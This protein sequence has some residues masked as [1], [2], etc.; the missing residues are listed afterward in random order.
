MKR[1]FLFFIVFIFLFVISLSHRA[2]TILSAVTFYDFVLNADK[3]T[4]QNSSGTLP[5]PGSTSD[6][7]GFAVLLTNQ[8]MEDGS[9]YSKVLE[10][11]PEWKDKT[12]YISGTYPEIT[13]PQGAKLELRF[14]FLNGATAT[15]GVKYR[16]YFNRG[17]PVMI[18]E[19]SKNYTRSLESATVDLSNYYEQKGSFMLY[20]SVYATSTQDWACWVDAKIVTQGFPDLTITNLWVDANRYVHYRIKNIGEAPVSP[21]SAAVTNTLYLNGVVKSSDAFTRTIN[22]GEEYESYF[23]NYQYPF[24]KNNET[25]RVCADTGNVIKESNEG[26]NCNE[27]VET[28]SL[29]GIK[30]DTGCT[31]V[32]VEIYN[33]KGVLLQSGLSDA[34]SFYSTGLILLSGSYKVVLSKEGCSFEPSERSVSVSP[35][36]VFLTSFVC[37]CRKGPDLLISAIDYSS[38]EGIISYKVKNIGDEKTNSYFT[39]SLYIDGYYIAEDYFN[40]Y[41]NPGEE[42]SRTFS[43]S[44]VPGP[45]E[46]A[47]KVCADFKY[48]V[49]ES[50]ESNNCFEVKKLFPDLA[51]VSIECDYKEKSVRFA[52][53]NKGKEKVEKPFEVAIYVDGLLKSTQS[54]SK[55]IGPG[56]MYSS[57]FSGVATLC[58]DLNLKIVVDSN[59]KIPEI[60]EANNFMLKECK[61]E[62]L[63]DLMVSSVSLSGNQICYKVKNS[64]KKETSVSF[65][66]L[67]LIDGIKASEDEVSQKI[68]MEKEL[69]RCFSYSLQ[70]G[71]HVVKVCADSG[72]AVRESNEENNC[73]EQVFVIEERL[74]DIIVDAIQ[75][76]GDNEI[77]FTVKNIGS[78]FAVS[79]WSAFADVYFNG[80][81]KGTID[82]RNPS[83]VSGGGFEK[84]NG[85]S[86]YK[87]GW[88]ANNSTLVRILIDFTNNI[89][90]TDKSNN[91]KES[92]IEPCV[93]K[94]PDLVITE[95]TVIETSI[96]YTIKNIGEGVAGSRSSSLTSVQPTVTPCSALYVD[97]VMISE[98]C[99]E[100]PLEPGNEAQGHFVLH[101]K[102]TPPNEVIKVCADWENKINETD[103]F[104]NCLERIIPVEEK[105]PEK[106]CGC[107]ETSKFSAKVTGYDGFAV[108]N[109]TGGPEAEIVIAI[110]D[111]APG[112]AGMFYIYG[113]DGSLISKFKARFTTKDR[114]VVG[115]FLKDNIYQE[116]AV[117]IDED[118]KVYIYDSTGIMLSSFSA[119]FTPF[120][121]LSSGNLQ[122]DGKDEIIIAIDEDDKVYVYT[123]EGEKILEYQIPWDFDGANYLGE[124]SDHN[125]AV[126]VGN[127]FGD[128]YDEVLLLDQNG[129]KSLVYI[130]SIV[131]NSLLLKANLMVRFTKYDVLTTGNVIG[132]EREEIIIA[133]DED[134]MIYVYDAMAGL[135]KIRYAEITPVD[136]I[137]ASNLFGDS[138]DE[139]ILAQDDH[140]YIFIFSEEP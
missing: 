114:I 112:D 124:K 65:K 131:G 60:S 12:G 91:S 44:Y 23:K 96:S 84:T 100:S 67:L 71:R 56:E 121:T 53:E 102:P 36:Q 22:P 55:T 42:S 97:G 104:N 59:E 120:D 139:I 111:D 7:R 8:L 64:G 66:N 86:T 94:L 48:Q 5:Y 35:N 110:D 128:V 137:A 90:E 79:S 108:G 99:L 37:S 29:G 34:S 14:G 17:Q 47:I 43:Y 16:V 115:D 82:L 10:T 83:S 80:V 32:K 51:L 57:V 63:S 4:W 98:S 2:Y 33:E 107:F 117:A 93:I 25:M 129:D 6:A 92:R 49:K 127:V 72:L 122:G 123:G 75:C 26:N 20:V 88:K 21:L 1:N 78:D 28:P 130:Y 95:I 58:T 126:A 87:T 134:H 30:V 61:C 52:I 15:D 140:D 133:I 19:K 46:D 9:N 38:N 70:T 54:V 27:K 81:K 3:A 68:D 24:P 138:Q 113:G 125:D 69:S 132:N 85:I 18:F 103:D 50:N 136:G 89:R 39:N 135:L 41:L 105:L 106:P 77:C 74:P 109:V 73:I 13:I 116:I 45:P 118:D 101:F 40:S 11:H 119:R 62:E 76:V 31:Q